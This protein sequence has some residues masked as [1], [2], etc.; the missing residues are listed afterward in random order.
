MARILKTIS[1]ILIISTKALC[2][3][4]SAAPVFREAELNISVPSGFTNYIERQSVAPISEKFINYQTE[5]P[6]ALYSAGVTTSLAS[7]FSGDIAYRNHIVKLFLEKKYTETVEQYLLY[8][9]K[10]LSQ[11]IREEAKL[12]YSI[13]LINLGKAEG[14]NILKDI[15]INGKIFY[16]AS[17]DKYAQIHWDNRDFRAITA[18]DKQ[19]PFPR[20]FFSALVLSNI[21]LGHVQEAKKLLDNNPDMIFYI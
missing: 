4:F 15:C 2:N 3:T 7:V 5:E 9:N 8:E 17:C 11:N 18:L 21:K 16:Q 14:F 12:L 20:Y 6:S 13:S 1:V 10:L 19:K